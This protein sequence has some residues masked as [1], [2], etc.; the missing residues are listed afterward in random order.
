MS[1]S[2]EIKDLVSVVI[3]VYNAEKYV[4]EAIRSVISQTYTNIEVIVVDDCSTDSSYDILRRLQAEDKRIKV[5]RNVKNEGVCATR[6]FG[7]SHAAANWIA[8]LDSDDMWCSE[9][10]EK[11][12]QLHTQKTDAV[13]SYTASYY[14]DEKGKISSFILHAYSRTDISL[15]LRK[16]VITCS[17]VVVRKDV[18]EKYK[19]ESDNMIEDY[20]AWLQILKEY[21]IAYGIDKPLVKYR[22]TPNS[23]SSSRIKNVCRMVRSYRCVGFG[24]FKSVFLT[25]LYAQY[26]LSYQSKIKWN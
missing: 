13:L 1:S 5:Y 15:L 4:E 20:V 2:V 3:P 22:V 21:E 16:N 12:M 9:K 7:I 26:S 18:I 19:M 25:F 23:R 10:L 17:S 11:Q 6:N 24:V 8:F 14:I